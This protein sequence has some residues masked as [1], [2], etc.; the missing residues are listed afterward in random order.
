M[1]G[2][3]VKIL[4]LGVFIVASC[5]VYILQKRDDSNIVMEQQ[6]ESREAEWKIEEDDEAAAG[7]NLFHSSSMTVGNNSLFAVDIGRY[8]GKPVDEGKACYIYQRK[9]GEW[10][11]FAFNST[12]GELFQKN[13]ISNLIYRDGY[14]YYVLSGAEKGQ[15]YRVPEEEG[16]TGH[17]R[18]TTLEW[19]SWCD[20]NF[21]IYQGEIYFKYHDY[22]GRYFVK[23]TLDGEKREELYADN[24]EDTARFDYTIGGGCLYLKD[25]EQILGINLKTGGRKSFETEAEYIDG[26]YYE[27]G[28]LYV[29][30]SV[31]GQIYQ[32]DVGTGSELELIEGEILLD[33]VWIYDGYLYYVE[34]K[35]EQREFYG[36]LK[37]V[38]L[39]TKAV[40]SWGT[41]PFAR[42]PCDARLEVAEGH[43]M[44]DFVV[45]K[46]NGAREYKYLEKEIGEITEALYKGSVEMQD[47]A[48][49]E[50]EIKTIV[51]Q[52]GNQSDGRKIVEED[53]ETA[54]GKNLSWSTY[55]TEGNG[56]IYSTEWRICDGE[57]PKEK[58]ED[59]YAN[60]YRLKDGKWKLFAKNSA[61]EEDDGDIE[62]SVSNLAYYNGY[63]YYIFLRDSEPQM[64]SS[65]KDYSICRVS[66]QG[67]IVESLAKCNGSF[68]IYQ[69]EIYYADWKKG[70][71][72]YFRMKTDGSDKELIYFDNDN[73]EDYWK[74]CFTVGGGC[75]YLQ[76]GEQIVEMDLENGI[77]RLFNVNIKENVERMVYE[78]GNLYAVCDN[79]RIVW[80]LDVKT[81]NAKILTESGVDSRIH[82]GYLYYAEWEEQERK[83]LYNFK[84]MNLETGE[85]IQWNSICSETHFSCGIEVLDDQVIIHCAFK[86]KDEE[87]KE[88]YEEKQYFRKK[89]NEIVKTY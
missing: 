74:F 8:G 19:L 42:H 16:Y 3:K 45:K 78:A 32:M 34:D 81:G 52:N 37:A 88:V 68:F 9:A 13:K 11:A 70:I 53:D 80:Q 89:I 10:S 56:C 2:R 83:I 57:P 7:S 46:D 20:S 55:S 31:N 40:F 1:K 14:I 61:T 39:T 22:K 24:Q 28:C 51:I 59:N 60:I 87:D 35:K 30:D 48:K 18:P 79:R 50:G 33:C 43:V 47:K 36:I 86:G 21:Y 85:S 6:K 44:A 27:N 38:N 15:I 23:S 73:R 65:G 41:V 76:D 72:Q 26:L 5:M 71:K 62:I 75:F 82:D 25:G 17:G 54:I 58:V 63:L 29:Y 64:G 49:T 66:E 84:A 77:R 67:G 69:D 12:Y 4:Y